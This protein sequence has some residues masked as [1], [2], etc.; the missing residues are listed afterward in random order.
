MKL[1]MLEVLDAHRGLPALADK[2]LKTG[3]IVRAVEVAQLVRALTPS[4]EVFKVTQTAML[5]AH[6]EEDRQTRGRIIVAGTEGEEK[7]KEGQLA[8]LTQELDLPVQKIPVEAVDL[9]NIDVEA[10]MS[11]EP[12]I[13]LK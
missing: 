2:F 9:E 7:F 12:L 13:E 10:F 3:E 4:V 8:L 5:N 6:G 1:S 11:M